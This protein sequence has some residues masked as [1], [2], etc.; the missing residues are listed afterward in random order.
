MSSL[1]TD[2]MKTCRHDPDEMWPDGT[3]PSCGWN[4]WETYFENQEELDSYNYNKQL[5]NLD[6]K[7]LVKRY[8]DLERQLAEAKDEALKYKV[9]YN[10]QSFE[11]DRLKQAR[12]DQKNAK[13]NEINKDKLNKL[14]EKGEN[15]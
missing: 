5:L 15:E 9:K 14:K 6:Q 13:I 8:V 3:C 10:N 4:M 11:L 7:E 2:K 1:L 12:R